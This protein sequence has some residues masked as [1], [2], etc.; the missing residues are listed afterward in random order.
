M[1]EHGRSLSQALGEGL[2]QFSNQRDRAFTQNL[3]IGTLRWQVRLEAILEHLLNKKLKEKDQDIKQLILLGLYQIIYLDTPEHAAV[4]ETVTVSQSLKKPWAKALLNGV[5]RNFLRQQETICTEVDKKPAYQYSHP[6]WFTKKI[7][8]AYPENWQNILTANNQPAPLTIRVNLRQQSLE[9]LKKK[10][11]DFSETEEWDFELTQHSHAPQALV[12]SQGVDI[13]QLPEYDEGGFSVQDPAAQQAAYILNPQAGEYVL[14]ACAAPGGKTTH[15]LELSDNQAKVFALEKDPER[16]ERLSEN[17]YRLNLSAEIEIGDA[18]QPQ[19]WW[20]E[21]KF[22]KILLDAPCS[23]TGI[24]RRHPDIKWH[25]TPEDISELVAIQ[26]NILQALWPLLK[27]NGQLLYA[28]CSILPEENNLQMAN[29]LAHE[30]TAQEVKLNV[31]WGETSN[32]EQAGK[33]ILP[34]ESGM[35]G[36]YYCLIKKHLG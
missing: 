8:L 34:G 36:F 31:N 26:A 10:L 18:S 28:T 1:V 7:R 13:T 15:I 17:L 14:D 23:A 30:P 21:Q 3:V 27:P 12:F 35:D 9:T 16:V 33:Q 19:E 4:S 24:I 22:D 6:Q 5:L 29:F 20:S 11:L 32:Q 25:R 2:A